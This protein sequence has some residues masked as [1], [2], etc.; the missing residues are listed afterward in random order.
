VIVFD[1]CWY[2]ALSVSAAQAFMPASDE[3]QTWKVCATEI[4]KTLWFCPRGFAL[5]LPDTLARAHA[6]AQLAAPGLLRYALALA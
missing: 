4:S 1:S 3:R 6:R 2:G 5:G